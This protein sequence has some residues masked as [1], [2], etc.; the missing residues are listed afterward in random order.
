[1]Y[2]LVATAFSYYLE[3]PGLLFEGMKSLYLK[4]LFIYT[5]VA[6]ENV[7]ERERIT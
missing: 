4:C 1:M 7:T 5:I 2:I 6:R 3:I